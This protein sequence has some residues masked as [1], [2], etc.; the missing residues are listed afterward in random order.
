MLPI[1]RILLVLLLFWPG[2]LWSRP[3][4]TIVR[5][6]LVVTIFITITITITITIHMSLLY[7][8]LFQYSTILYYIMQ[9]RLD[10][11]EFSEKAKLGIGKMKKA[12]KTVRHMAQA[13]SPLHEYVIYIHEQFY[14]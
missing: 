7:Y 8:T 9:A 5:L 10:N 11:P 3:G 13:T 4:S 12:I 1:F 14:V 2:R 6:P